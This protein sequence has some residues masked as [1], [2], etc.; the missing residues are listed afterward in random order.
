ML[1][2]KQ[3]ICRLGLTNF[4]AKLQCQMA[5][6]HSTTNQ[7]VLGAHHNADAQNG[8]IFVSLRFEQIDGVNNIVIF[9]FVMFQYS[10]MRIS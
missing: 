3:R 1:V 9:I 2:K 5:Q 8:Q 10:L 7:C 6:F 4:T